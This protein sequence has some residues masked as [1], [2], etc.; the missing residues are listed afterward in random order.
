MPRFMLRLSFLCLALLLPAVS[1]AA[2][3][4]DPPASAA[5]RQLS[6]ANE[7]WSGDFEQMLDRRLIRV[8][9]PYSRTLYFHD[10]GRE[11]GLT[12]E[13]ARNFERYINRK[14]AKRLQKRPVTVVIVPATRE[15]LLEDLNNGLGDIVA[16]NLTETPERLEVADFL[17]PD[18]F[19]ISELVLTGPAAMPVDS[20]EELAGRTVHV[21]P[22][23]SYYQSLA[24]LNQ[25]LGSAGRSPVNI[26]SVPDAIEDEDLMEM[27]NAGVIGISVVDD[28]KADIWAKVLPNITVTDVAVRSAG[29]IGWAFRKQSPQLRAVLQDFYVS[30]VKK[31]RL[32]EQS[33]IAFNK[34]IKQIGNNT[35]DSDWRRFADMLKLFEKYGGQYRFDPLML[36]AQGY[37]E[38]QLKQEVR[39][40][41]GAVG[42]MQ[43]LPST[44]KTLKVGDIRLLEPNIHAGAK[45]LDD[46]MARYFAG[47]DFNEDDRTLFAFASYNAGPGTIN[48]LRKE[49]EKRGLDP[50]RWFNN[51]ELVVADKVGWETTTYVR[52]IY[53]YYAAYKLQLAVQQYQRQAREQ[54]VP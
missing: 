30:D 29:R 45:Y 52:N 6:L 7:A 51:L 12:A 14:Y 23:S 17:A 21:R 39:G 5:P 27:L 36:A 41:S 10:K 25:R 22:S 50:D 1:L 46:L 35:A 16:G 44:G 15:R 40:P 42:V 49:A 24:A 13:L 47:V 37:Q 32:I 33:V 34:G 2:V 26:V 8:L 43:I 11:R 20:V 48:R 54:F 38:S 28:W 19:S 18:D 9:A 3:N 53:K 4:S 31:H